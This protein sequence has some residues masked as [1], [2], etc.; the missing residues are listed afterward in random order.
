[1]GSAKHNLAI[2]ISAEEI[3]RDLSLRQS[4][5]K[6]ILDTPAREDLAAFSDSA[7]IRELRR[8]QKVIYGEDN[9]ID[10]YEVSDP[11]LLQDM[12]SV[13]ALFDTRNISAN[14]DG[15][16]TLECDFFGATRKL[17][18]Q[19]P[20]RNQPAG[21]FGS[22]VLVDSDIVA[23]AGHC[24]N[25]SNLA[26]VAFAF[27]FRMNGDSSAR[28]L[29]PQE[30][31]YRGSELIARV[32]SADG[33]DYALVRL[34][35]AAAGHPIAKLRR[36]GRISDSQTVHV[37]GH[38]CGLPTKVA[39]SAVVRDN[40][41]D[42]FFVAN[43]D[44]FGGNSGSPVFNSDTHEVEG[45]LVRGE[46]DFVASG[47]CMVSLVCPTTGCRGEDCT[48]VSQFLAHLSTANGEVTSTNAC[49]VLNS[50]SECAAA[51]GDPVVYVRQSDGKQ[52][53]VYRGADG[54]LYDV[55]LK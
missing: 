7:L 25:E 38:P 53:V 20:F 4:R 30:D 32:M 29:L 55:T 48:R 42:E 36:T 52:H 15:T 13:V 24:V 45:L 44:T 33:A 31:L 8:K 27:G 22:G 16:S 3:R 19:E 17:C 11:S 35:R 23:T 5:M 49:E 9:R 41:R 28:L 2:D 51:A 18:Q 34:D 1:M 26:R 21:A 6:G 14:A 39:S 10:A 40:S 12:L 50:G 43:L 47:D 46:V 37:I 54:C